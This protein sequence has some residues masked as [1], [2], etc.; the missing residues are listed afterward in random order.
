MKRFLQPYLY[1]KWP[2]IIWSVI[3]FVLLAMPGN[4]MFVENWFN[5]IHLDKLVH[6][7][8]FFILTLL[9]VQFVQ[10][11]TTITK[12]MLLFIAAIATL[13]GIAMEFVQIYTG[14]DFSTGD[15]LADGA[16]AFAGALMS[17]GKK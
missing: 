6:F 4:G 12:G 16:G 15:M 5:G 9:W 8:L 2:T 14:R 10:Q 13:Y 7:L 17:R 11:K 3:V 1:T